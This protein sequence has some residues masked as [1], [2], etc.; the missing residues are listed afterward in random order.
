VGGRDPRPSRGLHQLGAVPR[1]PNDWRRTTRAKD[2][3]PRAR[4][5]RC[6]RGSC[7]AARAAGR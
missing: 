7:A 5:E 2:S 1:E 4:A 3:A 6:A